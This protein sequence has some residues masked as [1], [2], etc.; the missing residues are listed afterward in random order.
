MMGDIKEDVSTL[1]PVI[2]T[3]YWGLWIVATQGQVVVGYSTLK[4]WR[5]TNLIYMT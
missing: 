3:M 5:E 4:T 1:H 2:R